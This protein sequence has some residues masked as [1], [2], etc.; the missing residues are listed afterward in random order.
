M[1]LSRKKKGT[2]DFQRQQ[3]QTS[4]INVD[5]RLN[6]KFDSQC[7]VTTSPRFKVLRKASYRVTAKYKLSPKNKKRANL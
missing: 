7:M 5:Q 2:F 1:Y 6:F 4:V 3:M